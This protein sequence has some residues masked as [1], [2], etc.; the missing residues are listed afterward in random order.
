MLYLFWKGNGKIMK[1]VIAECP[2]NDYYL[3]VVFHKNE[4]RRYAN[5]I[6]IDG[7]SGLKRK[8]ISYARYLMSVKEGRILNEDEHVDHKDDDKTNDD[9]NNL[10]ILSLRENNIKEA[11]RRGTKMVVLKCPYCGVI[12]EKPRVKTFLVKGGHFAACSR[13]CSSRFGALLQFHP[14]DPKLLQALKENI[15]NEYIKHE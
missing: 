8:T 15:I 2:Y 14:N 5:L 4:G 3:Y 13:N 10:Q 11:K 1:R 9:I 6:P 12:F 7:S